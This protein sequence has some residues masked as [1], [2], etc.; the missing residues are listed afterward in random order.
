MLYSYLKLYGVKRYKVSF[1]VNEMKIGKLTRETK[2]LSIKT[3][4]KNNTNLYT[5]LNTAA[6]LIFFAS[7]L[8]DFLFFQEKGNLQ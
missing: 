3:C 2:F 4:M 8:I 6:L 1:L 7:L 5:L